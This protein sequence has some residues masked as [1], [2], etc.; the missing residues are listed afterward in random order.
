MTSRVAGGLTSKDKSMTSCLYCTQVTTFKCGGFTIGF[1][2]SHLVWDGH[3]V[4]HFLMNLMSLARGGPLMFPVDPDRT[5]LKARNPPTPKY[6]HPESLKPD[7]LPASMTGP[8]T[9]PDA[10][11]SDFQGLFASK[12]HITKVL[13]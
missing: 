12:K 4:V 8:F 2:M 3:G 9:T 1:G 6:D 11:K 10:S 7:E 5:M 13:S